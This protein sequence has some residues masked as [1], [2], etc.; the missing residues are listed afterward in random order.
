MGSLKRPVGAAGGGRTTSLPGPRAPTIKR[1]ATD[2]SIV[3]TEDTD[4]FII[5]DRVWVGGSKGGVISY[6]GETQF[7]PG[8]WAGVTLDDPIGKNDGSVAGVRYFQCE[9]KKGVFSRLTRLSR[10]P[11]TD[12]DIEILTSRSST[13]GS[14][15]PKAN[16]TPAASVA[17]GPTTTTRKVTP[18]S[19]PANSKPATV[20]SVKSSSPAPASTPKKASSSTPASSSPDMKVGDRVVIASATG[21][22]HGALR[23]VGKADFAE[24]VWAGVELDEPTGKNDGS[25]AGKKYFECKDKYGLFAPIARVSKFTGGSATPRRTSVMPQTPRSTV[26]RSNSRESLG[27]SSVASSTT[28]SIRG[29]RVRLGVTS[30]TPGQ[31]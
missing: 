19:P 21:V 2:A 23:F 22:R 9:P 4:S 14:D 1:F 28:S 25:V 8:E 5:G 24:G 27:G 10:T 13:L 3:L 7:A 15:S 18:A 31:V 20:A 29:T 17:S 26:R 12:Q 30:L 6:I 16:G 11:L